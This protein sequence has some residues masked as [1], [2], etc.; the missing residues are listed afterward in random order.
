MHWFW[1][2]KYVI[3]TTWSCYSS[4]FNLMLFISVQKL[5]Q[6]REYQEKYYT[7]NVVLAHKCSAWWMCKFKVG[8]PVGTLT[9]S[10]PWT[11]KKNLGWKFNR[12]NERDKQVRPNKTKTKVRF[13][14]LCYL[15]N[16]SLKIQ[17]TLCQ[18]PVGRPSVGRPLDAHSIIILKIL[19]W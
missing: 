5:F 6:W 19:I 1:P 7:R 15:I 3:K 14:S 11:S 16:D 18:T 8:L 10:H 4:R 12:R 13:R 9:S 17:R 2:R